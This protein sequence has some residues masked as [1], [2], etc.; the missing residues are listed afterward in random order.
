MLVEVKKIFQV[1]KCND[2]PYFKEVEDTSCCFDSFDEPNYDWYCANKN[3]DNNGS[4][5]ENYNNEHGQAL[6]G[7]YHRNVECNI[8]DWCP[9]KN[10]Q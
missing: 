6:G 4:G 8:P 7:A 5:L 2:C 9:C 1:K 10:N 3:A